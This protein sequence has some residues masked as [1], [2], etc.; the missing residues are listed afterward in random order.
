MKGSTK[1][2]VLVADKKAEVHEHPIPQR[3]DD[4]VLIAGKACNI[5]SYDYQQWLGLRPQQPYPM[6]WGHETAGVV[7][8]V[9]KNVK[10]VKPGDHVVDNIY[11]PCLKCNNCRLGLNMN[12]CEK[13]DIDINKDKDEYGYY[14]L[15]GA[16]QYRV[17]SEKHVIKVSE[18][19]PFEEAAFC[20][21]LSTAI[22]GVE[23]LRVEVGESVLVIGAGPMGLLNAL[24]ARYY[25]GNVIISEISEKK[26][27]KT[28]EL[29]FEKIV[30]PNESDFTRD[31]MEYSDNH[32]NCIIVTAAVTPAY[33]QALE[34]ATKLSRFLVFGA[35]FPK[36]E[37][38]IDP[39]TIH[40]NLWEIIGTYGTTLRD[41]QR[42]ANLLSNGIFN[43]R[44]LIEERFPLSDVQKAFEKAA[45]K[46][47]Y[48]ISITI[49][50]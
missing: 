22:Y 37:W 40:Y 26:K 19:I 12:L 38:D 10:T 39:N 29:G 34:I 45:E 23:R 5:C 47:S 50:D 32:L 24:V 30:D 46:D 16:S 35:G 21:P 27:K 3:G 44:P 25:G 13:R 2:G 42:A 43:V 4:D 17:V 49:N 33:K 41:Y 15:Y 6:A 8:E 1:F 14:G 11:R 9:G 31:V 48:R 7:V 36:P 20:E 18:S 28:R